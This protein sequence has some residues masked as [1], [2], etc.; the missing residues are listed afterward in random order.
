MR[1]EVENLFGILTAVLRV[2][3]RPINIMLDKY[4]TVALACVYLSKIGPIIPQF[5]SHTTYDATY[6]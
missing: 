1:R 2:L 5:A 4:A 6:Y 3:K